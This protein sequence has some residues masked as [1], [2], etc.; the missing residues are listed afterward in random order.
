MSCLLNVFFFRSTSFNSSS[1]PRYTP[2]ILGRKFTLTTTVQILEC[3][4]EHGTC[5]FCEVTS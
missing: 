2:R 4:N 3:W 5:G 1:K